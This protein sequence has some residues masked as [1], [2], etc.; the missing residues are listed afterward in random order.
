MATEKRIRY[1]GQIEL[2]REDGYYKSGET[3]VCRVTLRKNRKPLKGVRARMTLKWERRTIKT[4]DFET[5]GKPVEF[6]YTGKKPGWVYFG[7]EILGGDG[8]PLSGPG[9]FKHH[10]KPTIVT[11]I[12]ALF[13][14][15]KIVSCVRVP[16]DFDEFWAKRA[17]EVKAMR[18]L[19]AEYKEINSRAPGV[20]LYTVTVPA[21][22]G[23]VATG[24]LA[25]PE[26]AQPKSLKAGVSFQSL[27]YADSVRA[28]A[29]NMAKSGMNPKT[30]QYIMGHSDIG[31]TLNT[32]SH[33]GFEDAK[34]EL[35][36]V[37]EG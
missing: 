37:A 34:E 31:V 18:P 2:D 33:V 22:R 15:D 35:K 8:E 1:D 20:K 27:T 25:F 32:Y 29:L 9:V 23:F 3:A 13:D 30:L 5:T 26:N 17:A 6:S 12:G 11:E 28:W 19:K 16:A 10:L 14:A 24:F 4:V 7:F 21:P 36:R